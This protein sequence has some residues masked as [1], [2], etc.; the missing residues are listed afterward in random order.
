MKQFKLIFKRFFFAFCISCLNSHIFV[1]NSVFLSSSIKFIFINLK[2]RK[3]QASKVLY[4]SHYRNVICS[5]TL[6]ALSYVSERL[7]SVLQ[8]SA[9]AAA[10]CS[11]LLLFSSTWNANKIARETTLITPLFLFG[12]TLFHTSLPHEDFIW[13]LNSLRD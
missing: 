1:R 4:P 2:Y 13:I 6:Q 3:L 7:V 9:P 11:I 12:F 8:G 10:A 5:S